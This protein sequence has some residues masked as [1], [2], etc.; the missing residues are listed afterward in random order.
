MNITVTCRHM[1]MSTA[2]REH[3][4]S[5]VEESLSEF[6][7]VEDVHVILDVQR[8]I[9]HV[10]EVVVKAKNHVHAEATETTSD[11]YASIDAAMDKVH[12]QLRR[13]R[14]KIQDHKHTVGLGEAEAGLA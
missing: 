7:R 12:R 14:D 4:T 2:L 6:P 11:M 1:E 10:A 8:K 13:Q 9:N 5:R 3:A